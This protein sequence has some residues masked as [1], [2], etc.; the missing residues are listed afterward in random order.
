MV[1]INVSEVKSILDQR[2]SKYGEFSDNYK[3]FD[4][5]SRMIFIAS[6]SKFSTPLSRR[7]LENA[8]LIKSYLVVKAQRSL[9]EPQV[10]DHYI[11]FVN[12]ATFLR[13]IVATGKVAFETGFVFNL[14]IDA[15][16]KSAI[17]LDA[18][19]KEINE[20]GIILADY[21]VDGKLLFADIE[22]T[23]KAQK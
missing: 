19:I 14:A 22:K 2:K 16:V 21:R 5:L 20:K 11:D 1:T 17:D 4:T 12:Y 10:A 3:T 15:Y 8:K 23:K 18:F 13:D 7:L 9:V 6:T